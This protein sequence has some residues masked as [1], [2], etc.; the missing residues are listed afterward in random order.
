MKTWVN[1]LARFMVGC[2]LGIYGVNRKELEDFASQDSIM[3]MC[4]GE[5]IENW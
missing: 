1:R 5:S 2:V 4:I 3:E